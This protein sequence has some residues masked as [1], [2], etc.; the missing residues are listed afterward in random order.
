MTSTVAGVSGGTEGGAPG[1]I[2]NYSC[3]WFWFLLL[4]THVPLLFR[5]AL[6]GLNTAAEKE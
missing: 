2:L 4:A 3:F 1:L 5:A 6:R